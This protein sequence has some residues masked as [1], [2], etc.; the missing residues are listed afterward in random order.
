MKITVSQTVLTM[1]QWL[2]FSFQPDPTTPEK[3]FR[4]KKI[5][6][7][8]VDHYMKILTSKNCRGIHFGTMSESAKKFFMSQ[9]FSILY[10]SIRSYLN[11]Y[12]GKNY[13]YYILGKKLK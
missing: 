4:G 13:P 11:P 12:T 1:E 9:G 2:N 10:K 7:K 6:A 3:E 8:L 5:G